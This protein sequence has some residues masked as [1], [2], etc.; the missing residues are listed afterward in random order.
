MK[1]SKKI[2]LTT[3]FILL[4]SSNTYAVDDNDIVDIS[5]KHWAY[6]S[7]LKVINNYKFMTPFEDHTF[8]GE[9]NITRYEL[10]CI[11]LKAIK[12]LENNKQ[13]DLKIP[14]EINLS[15]PENF[16][17]E[18]DTERVYA[19]QVIELRNNYNIVL[20]NPAQD[21]FNGTSMVT[22]AELCL[23]TD[24]IINLLTKGKDVDKNPYQ[25]DKVEEKKDE[26]E[27][28]SREVTFAKA[29]KN[30]SQRNLIDISK[31]NQSK[32]VT[33][34]E[35]AVTLVKVMNYINSLP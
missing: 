27:V 16:F 14:Q 12:Y 4:L 8:R 21:S 1:M 19:N 34:Y 13:K 28:P 5:T 23:A 32:K 7:T 3:I 10:S 30:T 11:V 26:L 33:R 15:Y 6:T 17:Q 25:Y 2:L 31:L 22:R 20:N 35:L 29:I 24:A 18:L 9:K